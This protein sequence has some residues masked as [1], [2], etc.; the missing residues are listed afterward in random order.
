LSATRKQRK[1]LIL[2]GYYT[3]QHSNIIYVIGKYKEYIELNAFNK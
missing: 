2:D 3:L 1:Y